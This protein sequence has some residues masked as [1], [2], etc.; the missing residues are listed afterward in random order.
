MEFS[1]DVLRCLSPRQKRKIL[2]VNSSHYHDKTIAMNIIHLKFKPTALITSLKF[3]STFL[4]PSNSNFF[5]RPSVLSYSTFSRSLALLSPEENNFQK[6]QISS[7]RETSR[8]ASLRNFKIS[9][10]P[11]RPA[12]VIFFSPRIYASAE[13]MLKIYMYVL[14]K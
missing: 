6:V 4:R 12:S 5:P 10:R 7:T 8:A 3:T 14:Q 11:V 2:L 13:K 9:F 1:Q